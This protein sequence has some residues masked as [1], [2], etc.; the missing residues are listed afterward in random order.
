MK[1]IV[2]ADLNWA[3]GMGDSLIN[4]IP[5]DMKFFKEKKDYLFEEKR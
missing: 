1:A 2:N 3:I 5:A 4:H